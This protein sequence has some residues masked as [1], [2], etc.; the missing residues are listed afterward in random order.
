MTA[1]TLLDGGMGQEL[2]HRAGDKPTPLWST[3]VMIE[4]PGLVQQ[5]HGDYFDAGATVATTNTYALHR[6]RLVKAGIEDRLEALFD[7]ALSEA[8]AAREAAGRGRIAGS[9]GPL[10]ASYRPDI[11]PPHDEA[12]PLYAEVA[13]FLAPRVDLL[14]CETVASLAH[15]RAALEGALRTGKPVWLAVTV[16]DEDGARLRSGEPV[17]E[18]AAIARDGAAA[19]LANCSAPEAM[20]AALEQLARA[21]MPFGAYGNGFTM[22]TKDFLK[23]SPTVDALTARRDMG[24]EVYA[25]HA[26]RWVEMGASIV[27]GCCE[28]GPAHIAEIARRLGAA[29]HE[30][31]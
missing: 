1:I 20:P 3:Q 16:D 19:V 10:A 12:V 28:T 31:V 9:I 22:I 8:E 7:A 5:V 2:V 15:A 27:G 4:H 18:I 25:D 11:H 30:I 6:D 17:A 24:P 26:L 13:G 23:D 29:G 14:I 21:G